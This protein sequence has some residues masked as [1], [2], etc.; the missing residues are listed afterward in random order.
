MKSLKS[1]WVLKQWSILDNFTSDYWSFSVRNHSLLRNYSFNKTLKLNYPQY[2]KYGFLLYLF[3]KTKLLTTIYRKYLTT[4]QNY[5]IVFPH[6]KLVKQIYLREC[7]FF[8]NKKLLDYRIS[9][10]LNFKNTL[11]VSQK[12]PTLLTKLNGLPKGLNHLFL[13]K[14]S[15]KFSNSKI[16]N[17]KF[18]EA[19]KDVV[20]LK[21]YITNHNNNLKVLFLQQFSFDII[22]LIFLTNSVLFYQTHICLFYLNKVIYKYT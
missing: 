18:N 20:L 4:W 19:F 11:K 13:Q 17:N 3:L 2:Y 5:L 9:L 15:I 10:P 8:M 22:F 16:S 6:F 7:M 1:I 12:L 14:G 21:I